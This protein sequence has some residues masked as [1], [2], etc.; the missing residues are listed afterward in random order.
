[1]SCTLVTAFYPIHSKFPAQQYLDWGRNFLS[2]DAPIVL[3]TEEHLVPV[4][5]EMRTPERPLHIIVLPFQELETWSGHF[6]DE[7]QRQHTLNPEG[8]IQ[9]R[10]RNGHIAQQTPELYAIWAHKPAFVERAIQTDPFHTAYFFWCDFGAFREPVTELIRQRFPET[11][12]L[13]PHRILFQ[14]LAPLHAHEK[15]RK[16]DGICGPPITSEWNEVR[17]VGGLWGGGKDACIAWKGAYFRMLQRYFSSGRYAGNDQLVMLS[18]L[19]ENPALATVV[20][21]TRHDI[22]VWFFLQYLL[23]SLAPFKID[24]SYL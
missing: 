12:W 23:S 1:M 22:N 13:S 7:W 2:L 18:T 8:H 11:K 17:L 6:P 19:L 24:L 14:A 9:G 4:F 15:E 3:F 5:R 10:S 20:R 21:P 16:A